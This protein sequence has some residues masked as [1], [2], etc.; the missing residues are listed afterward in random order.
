MAYPKWLNSL[1]AKLVIGDTEPK[2]TQVR[3]PAGDDLGGLTK[4]QR[5]KRASKPVK[6]NYTLEREVW[7]TS[8]TA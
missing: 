7:A 2:E 1:N 8:I 3:E 4:A 6:S 5:Q